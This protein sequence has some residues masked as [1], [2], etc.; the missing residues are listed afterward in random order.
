MRL[1]DADA[2]KANLPE[3]TNITQRL[4]YRALCDFIDN[5]PTVE[6]Q[7]EIVPVCKVNF[8]KEQLQEI[9]DKKI[10]EMIEKTQGKW[11]IIKSPLSNET[12]VKCDKCGEEFIGND[13]EDYNFC[14]NCGAKMKQG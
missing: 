7:K 10:A 12:I 1:I 9:V 5:A 14:P 13:V 3:P 2:L 6:P 11:I 8:D 4:V